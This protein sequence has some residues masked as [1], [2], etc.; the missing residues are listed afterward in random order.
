MVFPMIQY[1]FIHFQNL[2]LKQNFVKI[3]LVLKK[4][5]NLEELT[6]KK[7]EVHVPSV[8]ACAAAFGEIL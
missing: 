2:Y 5:L 8:P 1:I 3:S 4:S 6:I 7:S